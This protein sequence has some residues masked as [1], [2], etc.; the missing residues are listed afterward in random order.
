MIFEEYIDLSKVVDN[1]DDSPIIDGDMFIKE[2]PNCI[3]YT[4]DTTN[5]DNNNFFSLMILDA[6][7]YKFEKINY[8]YPNNQ[9]TKCVFYS[10]VSNAC[11]LCYIKFNEYHDIYGF[12]HENS[13][14]YFF[15][16]QT[17]SH[18]FI[19]TKNVCFTASD[20]SCS[21]DMDFN[22]RD[23]D[24]DAALTLIFIMMKLLWIIKT[25]FK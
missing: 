6:L 25:G 19:H 16:G 17:G 5:F 4:D 12:I 8:V 11:H 21:E 23:N 18:E 20:G 1:E 9:I 10:S 2:N 24:D 15:V 13:N 3:Y 7:K 22:I 14:E